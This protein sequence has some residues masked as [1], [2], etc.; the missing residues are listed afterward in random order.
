M[1]ATRRSLNTTSSEPVEQAAITTT[2]TRSEVHWFD[3]GNIILQAESK[4][5]KVHRGVLS[6]HSEVF[7][8][9][10]SLP[11]PPPAA[12]SDHWDSSTACPLVVLQ[13]DSELDVHHF[14]NVIYNP[15]V[16]STTY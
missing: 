10:F 14:L 11:Q 9:M 2:T 8:D 13:G 12:D 7:R 3:D 15:W 4:L 6:K 16:S 5:F 1:P